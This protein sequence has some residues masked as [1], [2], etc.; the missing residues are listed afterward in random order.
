[1]GTS[2]GG[3]RARWR[4]RGRTG[5]LPILIAI[6]FLLGLVRIV[7][8]IL[9]EHRVSAGDSL[10]QDYL[11]A[12]SETVQPDSSLRSHSLVSIDPSQPVTVVSWMGHDKIKYFTGKTTPIGRDTWVT[13]VPNLR[14]FCQEFVTRNNADSEQLAVRLEQRLGLPPESGNDTFV[15]LTLDSKD[16]SKIFRPCGDP[17]INTN[18]CTLAIDDPNPPPKPDKIEESLKA[19]DTKNPRDVEN[20]WFLSKYYWSFASPS[21]YPWTSLGYTFDW[22]RKEDGSGNF[23]RWGESEFVIPGGT[24]IHS[25]TPKNNAEYCAPQ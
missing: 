21:P 3:R 8:L 2:F 14:H 1:M 6:F 25:M 12:V 23:V 18:S 9:R 22:A 15:E 16:V 11:R 4:Q 13:V 20:Y 7:G 19:V 5:A 24:P 17:S 10:T